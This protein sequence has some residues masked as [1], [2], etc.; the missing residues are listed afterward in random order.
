MIDDFFRVLFWSCS[1]SSS[2]SLSKK[3]TNKQKALCTKNTHSSS[4]KKKKSSC[5]CVELWAKFFRP[6]KNDIESF[7]FVFT[8]THFARAEEVY[9]LSLWKKKKKKKEVVFC[10]VFTP[11]TCSNTNNGRF[12]ARGVIEDE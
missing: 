7:G 8:T 9:Y 12:A 3:Q 6:H 10:C 11:S 5:W 2:S 1:S 4:S